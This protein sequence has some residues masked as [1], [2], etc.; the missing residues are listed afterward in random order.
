[1]K[2]SLPPVEDVD[3]VRSAGVLAPIVGLASAAWPFFLGLTVALVALA[4]VGWMVRIHPQSR[5]RALGRSRCALLLGAI[6]AGA[7]FFVLAPPALSLLR[8]AVLGVPAIGLALTAGRR[9]A[10]ED[11][12]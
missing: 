1:M 10:F 3:P 2:L 5:T 8:G 7:A 4:T 12:P 9:P 6:V 11:R